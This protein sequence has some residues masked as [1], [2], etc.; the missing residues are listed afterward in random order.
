MCLFYKTE[1]FS[2]DIWNFS[3]NYLTLFFLSPSCPLSHPLKS[4]NLEISK[5]ATK[6][7]G[8]GCAGAGVGRGRKEK[9]KKRIYCIKNMCVPNLE[10]DKYLVARRVAT[11]AKS[12]YQVPQSKFSE[13]ELLTMRL[14]QGPWRCERY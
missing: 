12:G 8:E 9:R 4:G 1:L 14:R 13:P 7:V 3:L 5:L 10:G 11:G 6:G 2:F